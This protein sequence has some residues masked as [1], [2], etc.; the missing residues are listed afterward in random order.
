MDMKVTQSW[1][2]ICNVSDIP[3]LGSRVL[4]RADGNIA[5]FRTAADKVFALLDHCPHKGGALSLGIVHGDSVTCP[6]HAWNIDLDSGV[7]RAPDEGCARRFPV[8]VEA[9]GAVFL[10]LTVAQ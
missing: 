2:R 3:R 6:L 5:I 1:T 7:A 9:D 8:R 10:C 4:E